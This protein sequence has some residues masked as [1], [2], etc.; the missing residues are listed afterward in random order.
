MPADKRGI[1]SQMEKSNRPGDD[2][3]EKLDRATLNRICQEHSLAVPIQVV[4]ESRG[5]ETVS[6]HMDGGWLDPSKRTGQPL[7]REQIGPS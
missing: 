6:Y 3:R 2:F 4:S 5:N 7:F 1:R